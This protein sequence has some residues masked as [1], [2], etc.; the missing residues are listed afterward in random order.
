M[1]RPDAHKSQM[2][3]ARKPDEI[4]DK[5]EFSA[6]ERK[7]STQHCIKRYISAL[8]HLIQFSMERHKYICK[9]QDANFSRTSSQHRMDL[10]NRLKE[11]RRMFDSNM[12]Q[13][14]AYVL[15]Y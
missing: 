14:N 9:N 1:S 8:E 4:P 7:T 11:G 3:K 15:F 12:V 6:D 2:P 13:L 10:D 5:T